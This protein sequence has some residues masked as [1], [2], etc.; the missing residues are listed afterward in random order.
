MNY[1]DI[2]LKEYGTH[3]ILGTTSN[4]IVLKY[5]KE[6]GF[7]WI[8]D[9]DTPWCAAFLNWVLL[10]AGKIGTGSL[11]ARSFLKY[12]MATKLP[13]IGDIVVLWRTTKDSPFGHVG[14]YITETEKDIY[15]L[16]GNQNDEVSILP[17]SK[18]RLLE[19]RKIPV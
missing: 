9:D 17:F 13:Q 5:F 18:Y 19:Y 4:P 14:F 7:K 8:N 6:I 1:L 3:D 15:I 10:K 11:S 2:A 16:G 12:G